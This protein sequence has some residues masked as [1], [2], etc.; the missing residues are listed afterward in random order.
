MREVQHRHIWILNHGPF[1]SQQGRSGGFSPAG[2][3]CEEGRERYSS[4]A[5]VGGANPI[6]ASGPVSTASP[7]AAVS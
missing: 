4:S 7:L 1:S 5:A 2:H 6:W 3:R